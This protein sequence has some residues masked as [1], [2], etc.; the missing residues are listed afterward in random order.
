MAKDVIDTAAVRAGDS[1]R[2]RLRAE[3]DDIAIR[4]HVEAGVPT[5]DVLGG[6][7]LDVAQ[8]IEHQELARLTAARLAERARR[9]REALTR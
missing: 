5:A 4:L 7:F 6:D 8:G 9:L 1:T 3:L 2:S